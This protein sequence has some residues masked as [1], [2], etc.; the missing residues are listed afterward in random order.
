MFS[1]SCAWIEVQGQC[2]IF[3]ARLKSGFVGKVS[4]KSDEKRRIFNCRSE[5][6]LIIVKIWR[7]RIMNASLAEM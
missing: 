7:G 2:E 6:V 1:I 5:L 4:R 3:L